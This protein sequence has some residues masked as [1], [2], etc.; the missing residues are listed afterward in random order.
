MEILNVFPPS[1]AKGV[2]VVSSLLQLSA[3]DVSHSGVIWLTHWQLHLAMKER[4]EPVFWSKIVVLLGLILTSEKVLEVTKFFKKIG[5]RKVCFVSD[6]YQQLE[7]WLYPEPEREVF[8]PLPLPAGTVL[9]SHPRYLV[10]G[11]DSDDFSEEVKGLKRACFIWRSQEYSFNGQTAQV[12]EVFVN[13]RIGKEGLRQVKRALIQAGGDPCI[14]VA[15]A[16]KEVESALAFEL[17]V[18]KKPCLPL[19]TETVV[20]FHSIGWMDFEGPLE[21][22]PWFQYD[23]RWDMLPANTGRLLVSLDVFRF[24]R[25]TLEHIASSRGILYQEFGSITQLQELLRGSAQS[26]QQVFAPVNSTEPVAAS[27]PQTEPVLVVK[28]GKEEKK[29]STQSDIIRKNLDCSNDELVRLVQIAFPEAKKN[30]IVSTRYQMLAKQKKG[31]RETKQAPTPQSTQVPPT[32][33]VEEKTAEP[34][35]VVSAAAMLTEAWKLIDQARALVETM[36]ARLKRLAPFEK[37]MMDM[38]CDEHDK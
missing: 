27:A 26:A 34:E 33:V 16:P 20:V 10:V 21:F 24:H 3:K 11:F 37:A 32:S 25:I 7:K 22:T 15:R 2:V 8:M 23:D 9:K 13:S 1:P 28:Q 30:S 31:G 38:L 4:G 12:K 35:A 18:K 14:S 19:K 29:M 36:Q 17:I 6:D 5:I